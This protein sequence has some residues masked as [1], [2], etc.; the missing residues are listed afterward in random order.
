LSGDG[1]GSDTSVDTS[2]PDVITEG[3][4]DAGPSDAPFCKRADH[5]LCDDFDELPLGAAWTSQHVATATLALDDASSTSAPSS[6]LAIDPIGTNGSLA[7]LEKDFTGSA[8]HIVCETQMRV[9]KL[10]SAP[11]YTFQMA[12]TPTNPVMTGYLL[13]ILQLQTKT[14][15]IEGYSLSDGGSGG[16]STDLS[17]PISADAGTFTHVTLDMKL[18]SNAS[19]TIMLDGTTVLAVGLAAPASTSQQLRFGFQEYFGSIA[20][21]RYDDVACDITP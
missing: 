9:E 13:S 21:V 8:S 11:V 16:Q 3:G 17:Q 2:K 4:S 18:G 6:L 15:L 7:Y 14:Q 12:I 1:G 19:I 5:S 10:G 20:R